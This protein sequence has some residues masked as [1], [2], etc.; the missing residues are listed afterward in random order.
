MSLFITLSMRAPIGASDRSQWVDAEAPPSTFR[1]GKTLLLPV[2]GGKYG[3]SSFEPLGIRMPS[4]QRQASE[5]N[6]WQR[7]DILTQPPVASA[8]SSR[9]RR[10]GAVE[11]N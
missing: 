1:A 10:S 2:A 11:P 6:G 8:A 5:D 4:C 9:R 7:G 3:Q